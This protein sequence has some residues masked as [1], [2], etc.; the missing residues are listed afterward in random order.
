MDDARF[1]SLT[2]ALSTAGSRRAMGLILPGVLALLAWSGAQD[3]AAKSC[4]KIK[5]KKKRKKCLAQAVPPPPVPPPTVCTP[6]CAGKVCGDDGCGGVCGLACPAGEACVAGR[7]TCPVGTERCG[8]DC[9][10]LCP[11]AG[12]RNP[13]TCGCCMPNQSL[14]CAVGSPSSCCSGNCFAYGGGVPNLCIGRSDG[15]PCDFPAQCTSNVCDATGH[16]AAAA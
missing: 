5:D 4:R 6:T 9:V 2:R 14:Y 15:G 3:A 7:C 12:L 1:D 13:E 10:A 8:A 11:G 16:C